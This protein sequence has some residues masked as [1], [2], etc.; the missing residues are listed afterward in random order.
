MSDDPSCNRALAAPQ[1]L[2]EGANKAW[3]ARHARSAGL[4][5]RLLQSGAWVRAD[6]LAL[7]LVECSGLVNHDEL[8][9]RYDVMCERIFSGL[10]AGDYIGGD[11]QPLLLHEGGGCWLPPETAKDIERVFWDGRTRDI[12]NRPALSRDFL[13]EYIKNIL[14]PAVLAVKWCEDRRLPMPPLLTVAALGATVKPITLTAPDC[15]ADPGMNNSPAISSAYDNPEERAVR[16]MVAHMESRTVP[17]KREAAV[18]DCMNEARCTYWVARAAWDAVPA[19]RKR[20]TYET[21]RAL[22]KKRVG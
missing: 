18:H 2:I 9:A 14:L 22:T 12:A 4:R 8:H 20:T 3:K 15:A 21:D 1:Q 10:K 7:G 11:M 6:E 19:D 16:W 17:P 5:N 13:R